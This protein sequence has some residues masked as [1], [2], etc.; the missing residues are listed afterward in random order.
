MLRVLIIG[1]GF[2]GQTHASIY[3]SMEEVKLVGI[4]D[5]NKEK[6]VKFAKEYNCIYSEDLSD[7]FN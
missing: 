3:N 1:A 5:K 2:M 4:V 7:T 6:G